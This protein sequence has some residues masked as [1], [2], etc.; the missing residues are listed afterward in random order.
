MQNR[1][2]FRT[3]VVLP[4][5]LILKNGSQ[6]QVAHTLDVTSD[7]ARIGGL[8]LP[9]KPGETIAFRGRQLVTKR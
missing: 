1:I 2:V 8:Y 5:T 6:K 9:V 3:R 4:V 7:S